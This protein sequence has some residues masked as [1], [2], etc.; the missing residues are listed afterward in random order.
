MGRLPRLAGQMGLSPANCRKVMTACIQSVAMFGPELRWK[1]DRVVGTMGRFKELQKVVNQQ[2][3]AVR[4]CFGSNSTNR[5]ALAMESG[6]RP[7]TAQS[8]Y[9]QR[10][11]GLRLL[12][13]PHGDQAKEVVGATP[14]IGKMLKNALAHV[15]RTE[16]TVLLKEP[17]VLDAETIQEDEKSAKAE[18]ERT[19][20]GLTMFTDGS[21]PD[22]G[23]SGYAVTWQS[24]QQWVGVKT[25]MGY[26]QEAYDAECAALAIAPGIAARRETTP[27]RV[28][29]FT[30]AQAAI[31]RM[32]SEEPGPGQ[33]CAI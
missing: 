9:R 20:P 1:G 30:D 26:N 5:G 24:G 8:E 4:G 29:I 33:L 13:L 22:S 15:G 21:R 23:A 3:R 10:R 18:A 25:H 11:S 6:L 17:E 19:R 16:T 28:T 27:E 31:R 12:S 7:A 14:W 2:A 32:A